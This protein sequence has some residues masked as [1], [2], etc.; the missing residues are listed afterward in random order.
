LRGSI[1]KKLSVFGL[2]F[3]LIFVVIVPI[4]NAQLNITNSLQE[5][6]IT[7]SNIFSRTSNNDKKVKP[8]SSYPIS[9]CSLVIKL[10]SNSVN[11]VVQHTS[12]NAYFNTTLSNVSSGYDVTNGSYLGWWHRFKPQ[13]RR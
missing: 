4:I 1:K 12:T 13:N 5:S 11:M 2:T 9:N 6:L 3:I 8:V 7:P 10:P